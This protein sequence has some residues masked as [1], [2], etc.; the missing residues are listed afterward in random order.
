MSAAL[1][2]TAGVLNELLSVKQDAWR[3]EVADIRTYL[4]EFGARTPQAMYA[5]LDGVEKR[6]S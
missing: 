6:L 2:I 3:K 1:D 4:G 5:E